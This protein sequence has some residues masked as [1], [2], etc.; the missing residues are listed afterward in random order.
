MLIA[1]D[2]RT[3]QDHFPGIGRYTY[4]LAL[5]LADVAGDDELL[6]IHDASQRNTRFNLDVLRAKANIDVADCAAPN[7]SLR[8]QI[9]VPALLRHRRASVYHSPYYI[10]PYRTPCPALV[11]IHDLVPML[12]PRY[13]TALQRLAFALTLRVA[14]HSSRRIVVDSAATAADL[15]RKLQVPREKIVVVPAAADP[16]MVRPDQSRIDEVKAHYGLPGGYVLYVGSNK[17]HKNLARLVRA[18]SE[19]GRRAGIPLVLAGPW[20]PRHPEARRLAETLE[21]NLCWN[22]PSPSCTEWS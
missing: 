4:N 19:V 22:E 13:F 14:I 2:I 12:Y 5:A 16:D 18:Y 21:P 11:T 3:V 8:E 6:L 10:M 1:L 7:F 20:D 9:R 17:P 15:E